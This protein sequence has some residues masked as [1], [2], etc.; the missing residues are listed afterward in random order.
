MK[1]EELSL[2]SHLLEAI[3]FMGFENAT[4]IQEMTIPKILEGKEYEF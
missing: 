4:P 2:S 3:S 1:F